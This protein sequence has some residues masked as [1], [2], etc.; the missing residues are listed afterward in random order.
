MKNSKNDQNNSFAPNNKSQSYVKSF[1]KEEKKALFSQDAYIQQTE[2]IINMYV[3]K[4]SKLCCG[5]FDR[6]DLC[7]QA[8]TIVLDMLPKY[9]PNS[10]D[11]GAFISFH[12]KCK[13]GDYVQDYRTNNIY[14]EKIRKLIA[15]I[16]KNKKQYI[17]KYGHEPSLEE[18]AVLCKTE[19]SKI[20]CFL[21]PE[22]VITSLNDHC[23]ETNTEFSEFIP[24]N[25][26]RF[27]KLIQSRYDREWLLRLIDET[28]NEREARAIKFKY[29]FYDDEDHSLN[30]LMVFLGVN[31]QQ[32]AFNILKSGREKLKA[33][34]KGISRSSAA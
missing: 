1:S 28:L 11:F 21:D 22:P 7:Q 20:E 31:S 15:S 4:F 25:H 17:A 24:D 8:W 14:S 9:S 13:L 30:D 29:G 26:Q 5:S 10:G 34:L 33:A 32:N 19:P 12:I 18:L 23:S 27:E 16:H 2:D 6:E 3:N